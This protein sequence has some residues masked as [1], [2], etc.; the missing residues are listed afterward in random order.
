MSKTL[1]ASLAGAALVAAH[2]H[3]DHIVVNGVAYQNYDPTTHWYQ[4]NPPTVIGWKA[5]QQDNGFIE[6]N[7]FGTSDIICHKQG[8]PGGGSATV[9]AGDKI[10]IVW[11]PEWPESHIGPVI[12]YLANCNGPC[13]TVNKESLRWF[14][15]G[16]VGYSNGVWAADALRANGNSW[17]VQIPADLKA[18]NYV[19]RHE[20][21]ALHGGSSPNGAQAYPQCMN[22]RVVGGGNNSPSGVAGT[23]LYRA[24]DAGILFNPYVSNPNY[25]VPGPALIA[26]AVSSIPQSKSVA[27]RT[28]SATLPGATGGPVITTSPVVNPPASSTPAPVVPST[29]LRT[30]TVAPITTAPPAGGATQT[31]WGQCGGSGYTGPTACAAGSSCSVLNAYYAQCV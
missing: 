24:T 29:T 21:I 8:Q 20:I 19:L 31:K 17:L 13:E 1:L 26:G 15:I 2:G 16:G 25:P 12:D 5:A 6:P 28:A 27:T 3:V 23:S 7:N 4:P 30:S 11:T 9:Q 10:S 18:G 14:K 22:L